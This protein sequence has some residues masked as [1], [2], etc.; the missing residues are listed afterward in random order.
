[1]VKEI[2]L[3]DDKMQIFFNSPAINLN[4]ETKTPFSTKN[5]TLPYIIQNKPKPEMINVLVELYI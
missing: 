4:Y 1:M 3:F 5:Y 2:I